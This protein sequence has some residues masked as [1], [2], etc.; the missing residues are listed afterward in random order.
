VRVGNFSE[1]DKNPITG[2]KPGPNRD[3][4]TTY[5]QS[6]MYEVYG[7][8]SKKWELAVTIPQ[9]NMYA[10]KDVGGDPNKHIDRRASGLGDV[11]AMGRYHMNPGAAGWNWQG[12]L[13][14][15][16]PTGAA[17]PEQTWTAKDGSQILSRDPVL[18]PGRGTFDPIIGFM[19]GKQTSA[20]TSIYGGAIQRITSRTNPY[21]YRYAN[22]LQVLGG[23]SQRLDTRTYV[24]AMVQGLF[25]GYDFDYKQ[26]KR[27]NNTGGEFWNMGLTFSRQLG[28][29]SD[30]Q[31]Y[32][33]WMKPLKTRS[34][35]N[36]LRP[37]STFQIGMQ[38]R[39]G[40]TQKLD[41]QTVSHGEAVNFDDIRV[42]G[43]HTL[44]MAVSDTC[45]VSQEMLPKVRQRLKGTGIALRLI[46]IT[47]GG[48]AV[49]QHKIEATPQMWGLCATGQTLSR[50]NTDLDEVMRAFGR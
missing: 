8:L 19:G 13:G 48:A 30:Y 37:D 4:E 20:K 1:T 27:I 45:L 15:R 40:A 26:N 47:D 33:E 21:Q 41:E 29:G 17:N 23:G 6:K 34:H 22:E 35:G 28:T 16:L 11:I 3:R 46:N 38:Y 24:G 32:A 39:F 43:Q 36:L 7:P 9:V 14:L 5:L 42:K 44:V 50:T 25:S 10:P 31:L 18:Q 2:S 12:L 49:A